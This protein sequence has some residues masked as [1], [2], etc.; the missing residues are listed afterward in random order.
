MV[1]KVENTS[2]FSRI[3]GALFGVI[4]GIILIPGSVIA[5]SWN[6]Y[7]TIHRTQGLKQGSKLVQTIDNIDKVASDLNDQLVHMSGMTKTESQLR[8]KE[9]GIEENAIKLRRTVEMFQWVESESTKTKKKLG[10]GKETIKTYTYDQEWYQGREDS[11]KFEEQNGHVNPYLHF[12]KAE[13]IADVVNVGAY[14]L[15]STL[16]NQINGSEPLPITQ[17][18]IEQLDPELQDNVLVDN[19]YFYWSET[20]KPSIE[21][22]QLGDQRIRF[23][24]VRPAVIS[25]VAQ[26]TNDTFA[27]YEVPNGEKIH[28]LYVGEFSA[29]E[30]FEKFQAENIM[31]A[32]FIRIGGF[33]AS[34]LGFYLMAAPFAVLADIVPFFGSVTRSITGFAALLLGTCLSACTIAF[35]WIAVRPLIGIP[36]LLI[37]IG[38]A[39][40][41]FR[42]TGKSKTEEASKEDEIPYVPVA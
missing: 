9:F 13:T 34:C 15:N 42:M 37:G 20:G 26:Q 23:D 8:D 3:K 38:A 4:I 21:D 39:V 5:L 33:L 25:L 18:M 35:A 31:M 17:E 30:M 19:G 27:A 2:W 22:P 10:G 11:S 12:E 1:T 7:R 32:W 36:M 28:S 16:I 6:E 41:L 29:D 24:V 14:K 40:M